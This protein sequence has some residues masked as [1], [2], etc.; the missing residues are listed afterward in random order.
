M[1]FVKAAKVVAL[2]LVFMPLTGCAIATGLIFASLLKSMS[3]APDY[4]E[5]LWLWQYY[6][7]QI[8]CY[9]NTSLVI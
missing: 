3:Y 1:L 2:A 8:I 6:F 4:E 9:I 5:T 7:I